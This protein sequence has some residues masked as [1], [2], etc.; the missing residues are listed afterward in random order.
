MTEESRR[1]PQTQTEPQ[2]PTEPVKRQE[3]SVKVFDAVK[4]QWVDAPAEVAEAHREA[5]GE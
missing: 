5:V 2:K 1:T 4:N 3:G